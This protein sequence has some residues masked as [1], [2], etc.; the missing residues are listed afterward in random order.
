ML[1]TDATILSRSTVFVSGGWAEAIAEERLSLTNPAN[2][3]HLATVPSCGADDVDRAVISARAAFESDTGW[4]STTFEER[5]AV[6]D[7]IADQVEA[8]AEQFAGLVALE[9]GEPWQL[10]YLHNVTRPVATYRYYADLLRQRSNE[11]VRPARA[12]SGDIVVRSEPLGVVGLIVPWNSP[13]TLTSSKLAPALAAGCTTVIKPA[14]ETSLDAYLLMEVCAAAGVPDGVVNL[15]TGGLAAGEALVTH[16]DVDKVFFT[17]STQAG[18]AIGRACGELLR[19]VSLELGGKSAGIVAAD[20]DLDTLVTQLRRLVF[21][22]SG[23][24][25]YMLSRLLVHRSRY[26]EV[27]EAVVE[28]ARSFVLGDPFDPET[29]MGPLANK[30]QHQRVAAMVDAAVADG[31][32]VLTGGG[33]PPGVRRGYFYEP[34]VLTGLG[35]DAAVNQQ[36]IFG[37]VVSIQPFDDDAEAVAL[38]N[39]SDFGLGG[40]VFTTDGEYALTMAR[41]VRTGTFGVNGYGPDIAAQFGGL[42]DSGSGREY[43]PEAIGTF[44]YTKSIFRPA[45]DQ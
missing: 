18:R 11:E 27:V 24:V 20:A 37:P 23:Q 29:T 45:V 22:N 42:K 16:R 38:A 26:D 4:G 25:C 40:C 6:L 5:A 44:E 34:T 14:V 15:V 36:E 9:I 10:S 21:G 35:N 43:G 19:P 13:H 1:A 39:D 30:A 32:K 28:L 33:R 2:E 17:G 41:K 12:W 8:H 3:Q 31:A 7:R